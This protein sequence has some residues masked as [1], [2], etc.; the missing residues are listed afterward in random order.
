M[1][2]PLNPKSHWTSTGEPY[3]MNLKERIF[4]T[5]SKF[6]DSSPLPESRTLVNKGMACLADLPRPVGALK[7]YGVS[8]LCPWDRG[9]RK[10]WWHEIWW[11]I[12][13][14]RKPPGGD[15]CVSISSAERPT[16]AQPQSQI[17]QRNNK[18]GPKNL[19]ELETWGRTDELCRTDYCWNVRR[20]RQ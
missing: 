8:L 18:K 2:S 17:R 7:E 1:F 13:A 4:R 12:P 3:C 5:W 11:L 6:M 15:S 16:A 14:A 10:P 9:Q 20:G 19:R